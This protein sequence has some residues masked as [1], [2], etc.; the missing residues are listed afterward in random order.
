M[1][2]AV[3]SG[4]HSESKAHKARQKSASKACIV[5]GR[6]EPLP[7]YVNPTNG[8]SSCSLTTNYASSIYMQYQAEIAA[9]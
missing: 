8:F 7:L 3:S 9:C 2:V 1:Q 5:K 6:E 4:L